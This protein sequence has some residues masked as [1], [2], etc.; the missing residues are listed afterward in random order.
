MRQFKVAEMIWLESCVKDGMVD[1]NPESTHI[2]NFWVIWF[3]ALSQEDR[4]KMVEVLSTALITSLIS[5]RLSKRYISVQG[6]SKQNLL[7]SG[8][9]LFGQMHVLFWTKTFCSLDKYRMVLKTGPRNI[10]L[11]QWVRMGWHKYSW[12]F[13]QIQFAIWRNAFL[14][15]NKYIL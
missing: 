8:F 3:L 9:S 5:A 12:Q 14:I 4:V 15:L 13:G 1:R 11:G 2:V 10:W 6:W 7:W